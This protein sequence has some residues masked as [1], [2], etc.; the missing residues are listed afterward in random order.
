MSNQPLTVLNAVEILKEE[1]GNDNPSTGDY[2]RDIR[3]KPKKLK[4]GNSR[5][6]INKTDTAVT[7]EIQQMDDPYM[8]G[9][10]GGKSRYQVAQE[11]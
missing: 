11:T 5:N 9:P 10:L 2:D 4:R 6:T 7:G 8:S 1:Y 3:V